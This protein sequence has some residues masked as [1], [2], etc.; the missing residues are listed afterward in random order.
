M[1]K[2]DTELIQELRSGSQFAF[3]MLLERYLSNVYNVVLSVVKSVEE[4][5]DITQD[6]FVKVWKYQNRFHLSQS[7]KT[8]LFTIARNSAID[9]IRK[10]KSILFSQLSVSDDL[11]F[12]ESLKSE[13]ILPHEM[14]EKKENEVL[15]WN[16]V[17]KLPY[18]YALVIL[19][20]YGEDF[21]FHDIAEILD[22]PLNT[23]RSYHQRAIQNL[24]QT[25]KM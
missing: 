11:P 25:F 20:R 1:K 14:F 9:Y 12:E 2:T 4:A 3:E 16:A 8:W 24:K 18:E 17:E 21:E 19:L 22:K 7:F 5:E 23:V 13:E 10:K 15:L 6:V